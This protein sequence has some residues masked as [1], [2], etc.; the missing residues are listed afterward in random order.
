[1][2]KSTWSR[3]G[4]PG[5]CCQ[6]SLVSPVQIK[7][8]QDTLAGIGATT[9]ANVENNKSVYAF[10]LKIVTETTGGPM[11]SLIHPDDPSGPSVPPDDKIGSTVEMVEH[12]VGPFEIESPPKIAYELP[13]FSSSCSTST[14]NN[15]PTYA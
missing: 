13:C 15:V 12:V 9:L 10:T 14:I 8:G 11:Q 3:A 4:G 7:N 2:A 1:M 5:R 6:W